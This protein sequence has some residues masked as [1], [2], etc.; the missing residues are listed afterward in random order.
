[1]KSEVEKSP[2]CNK[3]TSYCEWAQTK[4]RK[5]KFASYCRGAAYEYKD[6]DKELLFLYKFIQF[7]I[8]EG[9]IT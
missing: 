2:I 1:M 9:Y 5:R 3:V 7:Q 8:N 4:D 6:L